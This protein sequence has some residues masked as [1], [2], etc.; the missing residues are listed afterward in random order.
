VNGVVGG[1]GGTT[2]RWR[3]QG[4][5]VEISEGGPFRPYARFVVDS[6]DLMFV[7]GD[8]SKELWSR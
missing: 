7:F 6:C 8:G 1:G 5:I 3:V 4:N 2:G